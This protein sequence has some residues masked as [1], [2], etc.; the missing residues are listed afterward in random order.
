MKT[1]L[2]VKDGKTGTVIVGYGENNHEEFDYIEYDTLDT[3][4]NLEYNYV[5]RTCCGIQ[6]MDVNNNKCEYEEMTDLELIEVIGFND[7][8][9]ATQVKTFEEIKEWLY[10][11]YKISLGD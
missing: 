10:R 6:L 7:C 11:N 4:K 3:D 9:I 8:T 2:N 5:V 1:M